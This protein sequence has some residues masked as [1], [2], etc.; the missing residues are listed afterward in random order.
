MTPTPRVQDEAPVYSRDQ[1]V[2]RDLRTADELLANGYPVPAEVCAWLEDATAQG[3]RVPLY[4]TSAARRARGDQWTRPPKQ[5]AKASAAERATAVASAERA[6][7]A[8]PVRYTPLRQGRDR[9]PSL[10]TDPRRWLDELFREGF[11]IIDTETTGLGAR[12]EVIEVAVVGSDGDVLLESR[13]W[14]RSGAVPAA[15]TR[16]HGLT[17]DDLAGAPR[18]PELLDS[19]H[20]A[21]VG[22]RVLAWNAPFDE[23]LSVQTSRAWGIAHP[24]PSF[25]CAMRAYAYGRGIG[26]GSF[27]L[28]RAASV[29]GVLLGDQAH[30]G[31]ADARLTLAVLH[32]LQR[33]AARRA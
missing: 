19:L 28:A 6:A 20:A 23:R 4:S 26:T 25:E 13:V 2:S 9:R 3:G 31:A 14:P 15:S 17:I 32:S 10:A 18:W 21:L 27:K 11:V 29:E 5:D 22:R 24:L 16:I 8:G 7:S 30:R 33:R 12:D 1:T